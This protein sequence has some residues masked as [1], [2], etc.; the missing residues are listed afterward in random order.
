MSW[1]G[2]PNLQQEVKLVLGDVQNFVDKIYHEVSK[3]A[4]GN[5]SFITLNEGEFPG[6]ELVVLISFFRL[7]SNRGVTMEGLRQGG[8]EGWKIW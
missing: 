4:H 3:H 2:P 6:G 8:T 5:T 1:P 7:Q